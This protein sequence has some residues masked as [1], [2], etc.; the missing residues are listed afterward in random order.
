MSTRG[1]LTR[2]QA[3]E[4][5]GEKAVDKVERQNCDFTGRLMD[6]CDDRVEFAASISAKNTDGDDVTLVAYYYPTQSELD[7]AGDDLGDVDWVVEGFEI[8]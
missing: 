7:A 4:I 8:V 3:I 1:Q 2:E 6:D 5:V